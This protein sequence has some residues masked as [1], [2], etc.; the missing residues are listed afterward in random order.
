MLMERI[1]SKNNW[2]SGYG[3]VL[4]SLTQIQVVCLLGTIIST[5]VLVY[6]SCIIQIN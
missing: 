5:Q 4:Y 1:K 3:F 6:V 2:G